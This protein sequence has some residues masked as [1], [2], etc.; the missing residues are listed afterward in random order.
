MKLKKKQKRLIDENFTI[1]TF[2]K[3][4]KKKR[5]HLIHLVSR[6]NVMMMKCRATL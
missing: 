1:K 4:K 3:K 2:K 5:K 6:L